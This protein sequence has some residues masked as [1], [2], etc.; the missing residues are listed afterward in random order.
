[1]AGNKVESA[2]LQVNCFFFE[3]NVRAAVRNVIQTIPFVVEH[4]IFPEIP[5][6]GELRFGNVDGRVFEYIEKSTHIRLAIKKV[7]TIITDEAYQV[8]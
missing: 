4:L 5:D 3:N 6:G 1:M 7:K 8:K 2:L